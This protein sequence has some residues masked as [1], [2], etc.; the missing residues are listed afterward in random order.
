LMSGGSINALNDLTR[1]AKPPPQIAQ[2]KK[3][4]KKA[5]TVI[6]RGK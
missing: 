2:K 5:F 1:E 3:G 4:G 6:K